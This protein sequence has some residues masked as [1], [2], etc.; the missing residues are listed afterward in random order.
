MASPSVTDWISAVSTAALGILGFMITWWQW[1]KSGFSPQL[2]S[3]IDANREAI[4]LLIINKG[5]ASGIIDQVSVL[6]PSPATKAEG[7]FDVFDE[8]AE[9]E[10]FT[11]NAFRPFALPAMASA[12]IIIQAPENHAFDAGI[13]VLSVSEGL[14]LRRSSRPRSLP[15]S[16]S[17]D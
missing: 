1:R 8:G 11:D 13:T 10:G 2:T 16:G 7:K 6:L 9:F 15:N 5:R 14:N 3:R 4:E 12:R 17:S